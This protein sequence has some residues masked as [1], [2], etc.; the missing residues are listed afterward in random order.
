MRRFV[1]VILA[2][3]LAAGICA[4]AARLKGFRVNRMTEAT[5]VM[6]NAQF[7]WQIESEKRDVRQ[8][9]YRICVAT[10]QQGLTQQ[11]KDLLWDSERVESDNTIQVPYQGRRLPRQKDIYWQVTVWLSTGECIKS[12]VLKF[13]TGLSMAE[14][15]AEWI[16]ALRGQD[17]PTSYLRRNFQVKGKVCR[18]VLYVSG[19][20]ASATYINGKAISHDIVGTLPSNPSKTIYYNTYDATALLRQ[21]TNAM[22]VVLGGA[23]MQGHEAMPASRHQPKVKVQLVVET[24]RDTL[25]VPTSSDWKAITSNST[26][27]SGIHTGNSYNAQQEFKEWSKPNFDDNTWDKAEQAQSPKGILAPLPVDGKMSSCGTFSCDN[28]SLNQL[29]QDASLSVRRS[30]LASPLCDKHQEEEDYG[31]TDCY[32]ANML[33]D[34]AAICF[35]WLHDFEDMQ[36]DNGGIGLT[37]PHTQ[38]MAWQANFVHIAYMLYTHCGDLQAV[39]TYYPVLHRWAQHIERGLMRDGVVMREGLRE[40]PESGIPVD[41]QY[42]ALITNT[43]LPSTAVYYDCLRM[44]SEMAGRIGLTADVRYYTKLR[45]SMKEA[46]NHRFFDREKAQ[47]FGNTVTSNMLSLEL[48][49]VPQDCEKQVLQN[50]VSMTKQGIDSLTSHRLPDIQQ[51]VHGLAKRGHANLALQIATKC[52]VPGSGQQLLLW[53]YEDLAGIRQMEGTQGY[54]YLD[55]KP[56]FPDS[57]HHVKATYQSV[58]GLISSEWTREGNHLIWQIEVPANTQARISIPSRFRVFPSTGKGIHKVK[59]EQGNTVIEVGSGTYKL[60]SEL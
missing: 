51:L 22:G 13:L 7:D 46:Y 17:Y 15:Q 50:I 32:G 34:N 25:V 28:E 33:F 43:F 3:L 27:E 58:S 54:R 10:S 44:L 18:A 14:W 41:S 11:G 1:L 36:K 37:A 26:C 42:S 6:R 8:T 16:Q 4:D 19:M 2:L 53:Y 59:E 48:G 35:R 38:D 24:D 12:P 40:S 20:G 45:Q 5:G 55:M 30:Y 21:G 29:H 47:Y 9:A 56:C 39:S 52:S 23:H 57:L 60:K 31:A 49:L